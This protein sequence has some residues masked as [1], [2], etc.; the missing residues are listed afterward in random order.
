MRLTVDTAE[1]LERAETLYAALTD[2]Y[3]KNGRGDGTYGGG[4]FLGENIIRSYLK[5][6]P[7]RQENSSAVPEAFL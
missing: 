3:A 5:N 4:R 7:R 1:D 2:E 6:F